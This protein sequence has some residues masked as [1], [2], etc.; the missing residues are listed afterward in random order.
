MA[1]IEKVCELSGEPCG[2]RMYDWKRNHIQVNTLLRKKFRGAKAV[3]H[4]YESKRKIEAPRTGWHTEVDG[5]QYFKEVT[6][7]YWY[8]LDVPF[9]KALKLHLERVGGRIVYET[10][11]MLK[12]ED[13]HLQGQV[14]GEYIG[15]TYNVGDLKKRLIRMLRC[16]ELKTVVHNEPLYPS[17]F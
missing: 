7:G 6:L 13:K 10:T 1:G 16:R 17:M 12:V 2:Y 5:D 8:G 4:I 3:L 14:E 11:Y 15:Y 9:E